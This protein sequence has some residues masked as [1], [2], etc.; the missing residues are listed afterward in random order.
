MDISHIFSDMIRSDFLRSLNP[1]FK[2][3]TPLIIEIYDIIRKYRGMWEERP[4]TKTLEHINK[5]NL[6]FLS[7]CYPKSQMTTD[8]VIRKFKLLYDNYNL[9]KLIVAP[10]NNN[11]YKEVMDDRQRVSNNF[12]QLLSKILD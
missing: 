4:R 5:F 10:S 9:D 11:N 12:L 7:L 6:D 3:C 1:I 8:E 2:E